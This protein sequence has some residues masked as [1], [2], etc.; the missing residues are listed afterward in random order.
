[1]QLTN[2]IQVITMRFMVKFMIMKE[3]IK[4]EL[5][6]IEFEGIIIKPSRGVYKCPFNCANPSYPTPKWKTEKGFI[7]HLESCYNRPSIIAKQKEEKAQVLDNFEKIKHEY[8]PTIK[9]KIGDNIWWVRRI[10]VKDTHEWRFNRSVRVR[11]EQV[12]KFEAQNSTINSVDFE[13]PFGNVTLDN[14]ERLVLFNNSIRLS[15]IMSKDDA[16]RVAKEKTL[17]DEKWREECSSYR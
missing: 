12:L 10:V 13:E 16:I 9:Y 5:K 14:I 17:A 15:D 7:R 1:M 3:K 8:L 2:Y 4:I 11:Y 6:P